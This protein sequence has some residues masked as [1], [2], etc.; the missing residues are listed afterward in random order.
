MTTARSFVDDNVGV[1][2]D[3]KINYEETADGIVYDAKVSQ[4]GDPFYKVGS[5]I[6]YF[7]GTRDEVLERNPD[8]GA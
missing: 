7:D 1:S 2:K 6:I 4:D 8:A 3:S 5:G